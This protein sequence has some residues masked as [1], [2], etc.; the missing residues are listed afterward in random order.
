M[1]SRFMTILLAVIIVLAVSGC[2]ENRKMVS[3][4][5][6]KVAVVNQRDLLIPQYI[7]EAE[8][9]VD[10]KKYDEAL[11]LYKK[12]LILDPKNEQSII[13][14]DEIRRWLPVLEKKEDLLKKKE[15][16]AQKVKQAYVQEKQKAAQLEQMKQT[17]F[18]E[19]RK[20][21]EEN[22]RLQHET[23]ILK[24]I[25]DA[26]A[27]AFK[28]KFRAAEDILRSVFMKYPDRAEQIEKVLLEIRR[29]E[30]EW[31]K[32]QQERIKEKMRLKQLEELV[33][34]EEKEK[35]PDKKEVEVTSAP[36]KVQEHDLKDII[37]E[38]YL[39]ETLPGQ[40]THKDKIDF[41]EEKTLAIYLQSLAKAYFWIATYYH[42]QDVNMTRALHFYEKLAKNFP[43]SEFK[44]IAEKNA[45]KIADYLKGFISQD[46]VRTVVDEKQRVLMSESESESQEKILKMYLDSIAEAYYWIGTYYK[47]RNRLEDAIFYFK[48]LYEDVPDS[49]Y[50][51]DAL[52]E[53]SEIYFDEGKWD[54]AL[55]QYYTVID[56]Y[57]RTEL[58]KKVYLKLGKIYRKQGRFA[59]ALDI[60][61]DLKDVTGNE[62]ER[63]LLSLETAK[64]Y[65]E[66]DDYDKAVPLLNSILKIEP[67]SQYYDEAQFYLGHVFFKKEDYETSRMI[68]RSIRD[69]Y[70]FNPYR[71]DAL[72]SLAE[73]Y[74]K[75]K[76]F[77]SCI[78]AIESAASYYPEYIEID[79]FLIMLSE[80]YMEI[81]RYDMAEQ[82]YKKLIDDF[83]GSIYAYK[84]NFGI[85]QA[86]LEQKK[87]EEAKKYFVKV[88]KLF[89]NTDKAIS[90]RYELGRIYLDEKNYKLASRH[91]MLAESKMDRGVNALQVAYYWA[92]SLEKLD[93]DEKALEVLDSRIDEYLA[94]VEGEKFREEEKTDIKN[95][96]YHLFL[97]KA[98]IFY[99]NN[100]MD[101]AIEL[102][103]KAVEDYPK[104]EENDW[105]LYHVAVTYEDLGKI[106][107][108]VKT[109][110]MLQSKYGQNYW[111]EQAGWRLKNI[112]WN[113]SYGNKAK[114]IGDEENE[115]EGSGDPAEG[116]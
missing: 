102:Y 17:L 46:A 63:T 8:Q 4:T 10:E 94:A 25:K 107:E 59:K 111:A 26:R 85:G 87:T 97:E 108:A 72:Y 20:K 11:D 41:L 32:A 114:E 62:E 113:E 47:E 28:K 3:S 50:A 48:Q 116:A 24:V 109:Y 92:V 36:K 86:F 30:E 82:T 55:L 13:R 58:Y 95:F 5:R 21:E 34:K 64:T 57:P 60:Y 19:I 66:S 90:S 98:K 115:T 76:D 78:E 12:V 31:K 61:L 88:I 93:M 83:P 23:E 53:V 14:V 52:F 27:L 77:T 80:S 96:L 1:K 56:N 73:S 6:Y 100:N 70:S 35:E 75:E 7:Q 42:Y 104:G 15:E 22:V 29:D 84:A 33:K 43:D 112:R 40:F 16:E 45:K 37:D 106:E 81:G 54:T 91:L 38:R 9:K 51:D 99:K 44:E 79:R 2:T 74:F 110:E 39:F 49:P 67:R 71:D 18:E 101:K 103:Q 105:V 68:F 65:I 89:P 69:G